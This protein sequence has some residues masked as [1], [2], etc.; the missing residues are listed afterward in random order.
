[1]FCKNC[2]SYNEDGKNYCVNCGE[3]IISNEK[4][5]ISILDII[6]I[7]LSIIWIRIM[8]EPIK[9]MSIGYFSYM[10]GHGFFRLNDWIY[11]GIIFQGFVNSLVIFIT[12]FPLVACM[13]KLY[14]NKRAN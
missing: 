7:V 12:I 10:I 5:P 1:M 3:K 6:K 2:G 4:K 9:Q 8:F 11:G 14:I 13:Y